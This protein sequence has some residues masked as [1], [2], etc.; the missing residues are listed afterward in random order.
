MSSLSAKFRSFWLRLF[1][2]A[3][4]RDD[5]DA[6]LDSHLIMHIEDG[7]RAGLGAR[8]SRAS[9]AHLIRLG[10]IEQTSQDLRERRGL[11]RIDGLLRD[12][13]NSL[14]ALRKAILRSRRIAVISIGLGMGMP[15]QRPSLWSAGFSFSGPLRVGDPGTLLSISTAHK[16]DRCCNHL[17]LPVFEDLKTNAKSFSDLAAYYELVPA[18]IRGTGEPEARVGPGSH[19]GISSKSLSSP[20]VQMGRGFVAAEKRIPP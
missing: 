12:A 15:T 16:G 4:R 18:S 13:R 10:G 6:E 9:G 2:F 19:A 5:F 3:H 14:R 1:P 11:P 17:P 20:M 7:V 8:G